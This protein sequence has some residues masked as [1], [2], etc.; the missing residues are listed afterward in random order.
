M[1]CWSFIVNTTTIGQ[2]T[3]TL[4]TFIDTSGLS[5]VFHRN[6]QQE[7]TNRVVTRWYRPPELLLGAT[8][9]DASIDMW[10]VGCILGEMLLP[11][12]GEK[13]PKALFPGASDPDQ[14]EKIFGWCGTPSVE[15]WPEVEKLPHWKSLKPQEPKKRR[16][17]DRFANLKCSPKVLDLLDKLLTLN[18]AK[19]ISASDSL[20]H[21]WFWERGKNPKNCKPK[22]LPSRSYNELSTR[23]KD[24]HRPDAPSHHLIP[25]T[26]HPLSGV[27]ASHHHH[28]HHSHGASTKVASAAVASSSSSSSS[29]GHHYQ[30]PPPPPPPPP[31]FSSSSSSSHHYHSSGSRHSYHPS[32]SQ[33]QQPH[34]HHHR[35]HYSSSH[36]DG[37]SGSSS[38]G[39]GYHH[40][41]SSSSSG[42]QHY[43]PQQGDGHH[44]SHS[45]RYSESGNNPR[46]I[47]THHDAP[48]RSSC[49]VPPSKK[50]KY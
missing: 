1:V 47:T 24:D 15:D 36:N 23:K 2:T 43:H 30:P 28:H 40:G 34:Y 14:L 39:G 5:R 4:C 31:P 3:N 11:F 26:V 49:L 27:P 44:S 16:I 10:S 7:Y 32:S 45:G 18:P 50:V 46:S 19:R 12:A 6:K 20:N 21:D 37:R 8:A 35:S 38:G 42:Q 29:A 17:L 13:E 22:G 41:G 25:S 33:Q 9:Y 48:S